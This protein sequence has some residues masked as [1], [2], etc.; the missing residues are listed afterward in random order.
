MIKESWLVGVRNWAS[1][2]QFIQSVYFVGSRAKGTSR[3]DS[4]LD[5]AITLVPTAGYGDWMDESDIWVVELSKIVEP[6]VQILRGSA[7]LGNPTI[8]SA[9]SEHGLLVF[10]RRDQTK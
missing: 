2:N 3:P 9:I 10:N 6:E 5:I 4:D 8:E 1:A 7:A